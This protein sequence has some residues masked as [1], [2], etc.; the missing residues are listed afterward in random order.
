MEDWRAIEMLGYS[1]YAELGYEIL[2]P[3]VS[4][5]GYDF[6]IKKGNEYK[7]VNVKKA[8][9]KSPSSPNSWS[10]S[11]PGRK[12]DYSKD[13]IETDI[14]LVYLPHQKR[15]I[16]LPSTFFFGYASRARL[17]PKNLL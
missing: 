5:T 10:I 9:L 4:C 16:T 12:E 8:G 3:L 11:R 14:Y 15:F 7:S 13:I 6:I 2:V 17:I 1:H